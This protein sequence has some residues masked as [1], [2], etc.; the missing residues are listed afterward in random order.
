M[1]SLNLLV[2]VIKYVGIMVGGYKEYTSI[3]VV[4]NIFP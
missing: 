2:E 1:I 4:K 3:G